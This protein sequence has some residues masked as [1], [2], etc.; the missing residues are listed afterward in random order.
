MI[1]AFVKWY[2][3]PLEDFTVRIPKTLPTYTEDRDIEKLLDAI[4]QKKS[5]DETG[6]HMES[7]IIFK[8][9]KPAK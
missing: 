8:S 2:G 7:Y 5:R 6:K 4:I 1:K 3:E 9:V